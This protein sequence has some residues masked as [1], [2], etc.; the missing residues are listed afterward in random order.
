LAVPASP[1]PPEILVPGAHPLAGSASGDSRC[2]L[3]APPPHAERRNRSARAEQ[4]KRSWLRDLDRHTRVGRVGDEEQL[5]CYNRRDR[6]PFPVHLSLHFLYG[7][8]CSRDNRYGGRRCQRPTRPLSV[9]RR[10]Q[11]KHQTS[12][13]KTIKWLEM[14][15][16]GVALVCK[17][18]R[19][20]SRDGAY[21]AGD[22]GTHGTGQLATLG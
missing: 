6:K 17:I 1:P 22:T 5:C 21:G 15:P 18:L 12:A 4:S 7:P 3:P 8:P 14:T 2:L 20:L 11:L 10:V 16:R 9:H 19:Q 13:T